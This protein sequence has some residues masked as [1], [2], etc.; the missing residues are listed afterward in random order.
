MDNNYTQIMPVN[1]LSGHLTSKM[2]TLHKRI[3]EPDKPGTVKATAAKAPTGIKT[4]YNHQFLL[5][6]WNNPIM[7]I[8]SPKATDKTPRAM[9][10]RAPVIINII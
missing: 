3:K 5:M 2:N 7:F 10:N 9:T 4:R 8:L 6:F 1:K